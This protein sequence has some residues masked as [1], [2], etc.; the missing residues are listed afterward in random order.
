MVRYFWPGKPPAN[1]CAVCATKLV[2]VA[3]AI[4][5]HLHVEVVNWRHV[6]PGNEPKCTQFF[7]DGP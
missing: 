2:G 4:G 1:A 7:K 5:L 6:E 3:Q